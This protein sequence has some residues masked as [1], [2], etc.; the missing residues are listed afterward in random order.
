MIG[1]DD[2]NQFEMIRAMPGGV[3][4][5]KGLGDELHARGIRGLWPLN[6]WDYGTAHNHSM[7]GRSFFTFSLADLISDSHFDGFFGDTMGG[8]TED[9]Y[10][11]GLTRH[12]QSIAMEPEAFHL[13]S[14]FNWVTLGCGY[15]QELT[16]GNTYTGKQAGGS[17]GPGSTY[18]TD[19]MVDKWK[20]LDGRRMTHVCNRW[21]KNHTD[22]IQA[23]WINGVGIETWENVWGA[24]N[25]IVPRDGE[26]IRRLATMLRFL[27]AEPRRFF[28]NV[29]WVPR[30]PVLQDR[31][32]ASFFP[33]TGEGEEEDGDAVWSFINRNRDHDVEG[34]QIELTTTAEPSSFTFY[35]CYHGTQLQPN[36][37][38]TAATTA[39]TT[40]TTLTLS[41]P[42]EAGGLGCLLRLAANS[43]V[44]S[45]RSALSAFLGTMAN[46]TSGKPLRSFSREWTGLQQQ[47]IAHNATA[48]APA[49]APPV[50]MVRIPPGSFNFVLKGVGH[51][52]SSV[53]QF[54]WEPAP[55]GSHA[56]AVNVS[57]LY[58][59]QFPVT[60]SDYASYLKDSG[61]LPRD[62]YNWLKNWDHTAV[63]DPTLHELSREADER[64]STAV[65]P[66]APKGYANKPVT[67]VSF[68]EA[69]AYCKHYGKRLPE[70]WEFQYFATGGEKNFSFPWGPAD[71]P[72]RYPKPGFVYFANGTQYDH[73]HAADTIPGPAD[74]D[75]FL[76]GS[77]A[78]NVSDL[79][80]NV[81]Q[82]TSMFEDE[83]TAGVVTQGSCNY[84]LT[85][86]P[87]Y[88]TR[89]KSLQEHNKWF[90][91]DDSCGR[92]A[93]RLASVVSRMS[94]AR[95]CPS[96]PNRVTC[97][98]GAPPPGA[99]PPPPAAAASRRR[100]RLLCQSEFSQQH[101]VLFRQGAKS[102][103]I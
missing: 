56:R 98:H 79:I 90:L 76:N 49:A 6:P 101:E 33:R 96:Q 88:F 83:H 40:E 28:A 85:A 39:V 17:Y 81:W 80:G 2:R 57:E 54:P 82:Y 16:T 71:D 21:S 27:G 84:N 9:Y 15:W 87:Y 53:V 66:V 44:A 103:M 73:N 97:L 92:D 25:K 23:A 75:L 38:T 1:A 51:E 3:K 102:S 61:Y 72:S 4:R 22:E 63:T 93:G 78:F 7:A 48:P 74:V 69:Q 50:G 31:V 94:L 52:S 46:L 58:V 24:Y 43:S 34:G 67:F 13:A 59:D 65:P 35:D 64:G 86:A 19:L 8:I 36:I 55:S 11:A 14:N 77:S 42:I 100:L 29:H 30:V 5:L 99:P 68:A 26:A 89:A 12:N 32:F 37:I 91:F 95:A 20:W 10:Q 62:P 41:F 45:N 47:L 60:C 18:P 70:A